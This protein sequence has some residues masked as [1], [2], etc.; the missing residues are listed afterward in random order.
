MLIEVV[1]CPEAMVAPVGAVQ[2]YEV[3]PLTTG[4]E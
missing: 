1:P 4:T 3:A 2:V